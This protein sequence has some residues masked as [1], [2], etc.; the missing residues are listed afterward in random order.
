MIYGAQ[1]VYGFY[2]ANDVWAEMLG[3]D[4]ELTVKVNVSSIKEF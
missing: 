2:N 3:K 4:L 1:V